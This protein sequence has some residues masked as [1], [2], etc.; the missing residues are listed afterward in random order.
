MDHVA[1][2]TLERSLG[3]GEST[4]KALRD[5][6]ECLLDQIQIPYY[7]QALRGE[8]AGN[9]RMLEAV[10]NGEV[11]A[12]D[13]LK[14]LGPTGM[15]STMIYAISLYTSATSK[16]R[17]AELLDLMTDAV[18][19]AKL[20]TEEQAAAS[21]VWMQRIKNLSIFSIAR[22]IAPALDRVGDAHI[23]NQ[24]V[25]RTAIVG[26]AAERFR[27]AKQRWPNRL[28]EL[29]PAYL[30]H[31]PVDPFDGQ[32][33]RMKQF[34]GAFIVYS[35]G[36][37]RIDDHGQLDIKPFQPGSDIGFRLFDPAKRRQP[38]KPF[39][40]DELDDKEGPNQSIP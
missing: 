23:R 27:L 8:R 37:D 15:D 5:I 31:L 25:L 21:Q 39:V 4:E 17:R 2:N 33:L 11:S 40:I 3:L 12:N 10:Q 35:I 38:A 14:M 26:I 16:I 34:D 18:Q 13:L 29:T 22:L 36:L 24:A 32:P 28:D 19:V 7:L 6:Q 9:D 1:V 20:P 30:D